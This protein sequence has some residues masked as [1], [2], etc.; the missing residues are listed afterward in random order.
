MPQTCV[1]HLEKHNML[2]RLWENYYSPQLTG[3]LIQNN[4]IY[5]IYIVI[6]SNRHENY[7]LMKNGAKKKDLGYDQMTINNGVSKMLYKLS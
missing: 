4:K 2:L 5:Y 1:Q 3:S 7:L 6:P